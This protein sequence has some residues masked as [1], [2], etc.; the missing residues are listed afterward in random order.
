MSKYAVRKGPGSEAASHALGEA[1]NQWFTKWGPSEIFR[2]CENCKFM[3][4]QG[5]AHCSL[6]NLTPPAA[7][8]VAGC[9]SHDDKM[10]IPF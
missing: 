6:Y 10:E 8:I 5:P 1:L 4:E 9:P 3:S 7:I 2:T